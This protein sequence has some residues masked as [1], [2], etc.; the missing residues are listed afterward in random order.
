[1]R[2]FKGNSWFLIQI[3]WSCDAS[4]RKRDMWCKK[5]MICTIHKSSFENEVSLYYSI[6]VEN[7]ISE[8]KPVL[9]TVGYFLRNWFFSSSQGLFFISVFF[10][11][12][13]ACEMTFERIF[14]K[15]TA[16][17]EISGFISGI[18][19]GN[20]ELKQLTCIWE[21]ERLMWS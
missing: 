18:R 10:T 13:I 7:A 20:I 15:N 3:Y 16:F 17:S 12:V 9:P 4:K 21:C 11:H 14:F 6:K 5:Y 8:T 2:Y 19:V 1:M